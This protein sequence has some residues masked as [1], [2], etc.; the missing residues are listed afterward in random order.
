MVSFGCCPFPSTQASRV[1]D[2]GM[3]GCSSTPK[4]HQ[5]TRCFE[6]QLPLAPATWRACWIQQ[7]SKV[8]SNTIYISLERWNNRKYAQICASACWLVP[9][10][11]FFVA[12]Q[13]LI[14]IGPNRHPKRESYKVPAGHMACEKSSAWWF[15]SS[16]S[17]AIMLLH[18]IDRFLISFLFIIQRRNV[19][20]RVWLME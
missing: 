15:T 3:M 12:C 7:K 20:E 11:H 2:Q 16:A 5:P 13:N 9:T 17:M 18:D 6:L 8:F 1:N 14:C 19:Q 10:S 4:R